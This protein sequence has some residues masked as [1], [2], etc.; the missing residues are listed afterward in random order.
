MLGILLC[1]K[2]LVHMAR[3]L[4][5][6]NHRLEGGISL[7]GIVAAVGFEALVHF[8]EQIYSKDLPYGA[9]NSHNS[10]PF[11]SCAATMGVQ[12]QLKL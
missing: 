7:W 4:V 2:S 6:Q 8:C 12:G 10:T 9:K 5:P 3:M 1:G 11:R